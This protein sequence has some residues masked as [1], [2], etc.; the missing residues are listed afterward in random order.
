MGMIKELE[1]IYPEGSNLTILNTYYSYA[2]YDPETHKKIS[3]DFLVIV[4]KDLD[5]GEVKYHLIYKPSYLY[6]ELK[7]EYTVPD[8]NLLFIER[9][10]V[11]PREVPF[12]E[13]LLD[14]AKETGNEDFYKANITSGNRA[15]NLKL[16]T[17][18]NI[19]NSDSDIQDHYRFRFAMTYQN[20]PFPISKG[21]FDIEV[22]SKFSNSDIVNNGEAD[23]PIN[24]VSF[25]NEATDECFT[26]ILRDKRNPLIQIFEDK[27][28]SGQINQK[29]IH[30]FVIDK[31]GGSEKAEK[32][33]LSNTKFHLYFYDYEIQL[34]RDLFAAIHKLKPI[35]LAGWNSSSFDVDF[36]IRRIQYLG[37]DP[38]DIMCDQS[39]PVKVVKNYIDERHINEFAERTDYTF[40]S[41]TTVFIDQLIQ[42]ASR[43]K[44][45]IGSFKSFRLD[46]IGELEADVKKLD[47]SHITR[48][49]VELPWL[50]FETFTLY[51]I[52]DVIVQ[53]CIEKSTGDFD[54]I[55]TKC[56]V[57]NTSYRKGHRQTVYL[58]NRMQV[59]WYKKGL[60]IGNNV[61]KFGDKPKEK[62]PGALVHDPLKTGEYCR[63]KLGNRAILICDNMIDF[64]FKALYPS[65]IG[66]NNIAPNTQLG[67]VNIPSKV[68]KNENLYNNS[69]YT[70]SGEFIENMVADNFIEFAERWF[71]LAGIKEIIEDIDDLY[72]ANGFDRYSKTVGTGIIGESMSLHKEGELIKPF[73]ITNSDR[74]SRPF[75]IYKDYEVHT[76]EELFERNNK[77]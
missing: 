66:E 48:D 55:F 67:K 64:D 53:K 60:I 52:M 24:C 32:F 21:F 49:I 36:I 39:W 69:N 40:I 8:Y 27:V 68:Y 1:K 28:N 73:E 11:V 20:N 2:I 75:T 23:S 74:Y 14:I 18:T 61:N 30:D 4:Y 63:I 37:Y 56:L 59:D 44:S 26:F 22:D 43:R 42:Y 19:F 41:G 6:Y 77:K 29:F 9:D 72:I 50:D 38:A 31:V 54:Y 3:D 12:S 25:L 7:P 15:N 13:L 5:S 45:K 34:L 17:A 76:Y 65:L 62:F 47:Y 35:I 58:T 71:H 70:R 57:N 16:H 51:N 33:G 46:D 10:K